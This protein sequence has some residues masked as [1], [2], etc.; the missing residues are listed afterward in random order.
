MSRGTVARVHELATSGGLTQ[1]QIAREL[2]VS[3]AFVS[4]TRSRA[5][6][7]RRFPISDVKGEGIDHESCMLVG[8]LF[9]IVTREAVYI[10]HKRRDGQLPNTLHGI[11]V[12]L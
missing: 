4:R 6:Q 12:S 11:R 2:G 8:S 7:L 9:A 5:Q 3:Q 10:T 1:G